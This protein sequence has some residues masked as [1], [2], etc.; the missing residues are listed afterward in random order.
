MRCVIQEL[1]MLYDEYVNF[2]EDYLDEADYKTWAEQVADEDE[3]IEYQ[4]KYMQH[5]NDLKKYYD[6]LKVYIN[7]YLQIYFSILENKA[8]SLR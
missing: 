4:Q 8:F 2:P 6:K 7:Q 1:Y 5:M 3:L